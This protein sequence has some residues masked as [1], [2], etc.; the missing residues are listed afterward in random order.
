[1]VVCGWLCVD[2]CVW[3]TIVCVDGC[4]CK[5]NPSQH[6][7]AISTPYE[8]TSYTTLNISH[9]NTHNT[10]SIISPHPSSYP[11]NISLIS[12]YPSFHYIHHRTH[13]SHY[14]HHPHYIYNLTTHL[15][16]VHPSPHYTM[17]PPR[18]P[19]TA[20]VATAACLAWATGRW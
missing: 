7:H 20:T 6:K 2:G 8:H 15:T 4:V 11:P 16:T 17:P 13:P 10:T 19:P 5:R 9:F 1:M 3:M 12:L 18:S 14:I